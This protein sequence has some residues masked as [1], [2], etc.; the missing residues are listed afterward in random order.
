MTVK[1]TI[2]SHGPTT[3]RSIT[4]ISFSS[5]RPCLAAIVPVAV[6]EQPIVMLD[7]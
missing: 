3:V 2:G 1:C 4:I 6:T 7:N 5:D